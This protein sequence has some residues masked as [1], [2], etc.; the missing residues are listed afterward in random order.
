MEL[1]VKEFNRRVKRAFELGNKY[2]KTGA[3][4][5]MIMKDGY[6]K[7]YAEQLFIQAKL[8]YQGSNNK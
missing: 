4:F 3:I 8:H 5:E 7:E 6:S 1:T 2:G